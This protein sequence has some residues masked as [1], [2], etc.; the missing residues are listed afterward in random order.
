VTDLMV[1]TTGR[2]PRHVLTVV[3]FD[4]LW[5]RLGLG[6]SPAVLQLASPGRTASERRDVL[7]AGWQGLRERGLAGP[8]GPD[9]EAA[10]LL[11]LL[12]RPSQQLELRGSWSRPVRAVAA[13]DAGAGVLAVRQDATITLAACS[14]LP[15]ALH[16]VLPAA[17]PGPGR[18]AS[19]PSAA[20]AA[21]LAEHRTGLRA[22]LIAQGV[23]G[24]DAG[25]LQRMLA[26]GPGHAQVVAVTAD[27]A[28]MAR[29]AGGILGI[30]DGPGGRYLMTR[31]L[32]ADAVEWSTLAPADARSVRHRMGVMIT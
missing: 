12:A 27:A 23:P 9:P 8:S 2:P 4:V 19:V 5:E 15:S 11:G 1:G 24:P 7:R 10:R 3:E 22:A 16:D 14:S 29:R 32:G 20:L 30:L 25:L 21:A 6:P 31:L 17:P 26:P 18:A 28:G 13:M